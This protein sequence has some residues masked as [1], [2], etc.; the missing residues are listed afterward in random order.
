MVMMRPAL[1]VEVL[2]LVDSAWPSQLPAVLHRLLAGM[3]YIVH[4]P[5]AHRSGQRG[6]QGMRQEDYIGYSVDEKPA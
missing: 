6:Q 3:S 2:L 5:E 4:R 1:V